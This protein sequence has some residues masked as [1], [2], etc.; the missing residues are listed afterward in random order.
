[1]TI[2]MESLNCNLKL[3]LAVVL[4]GRR[5]PGGITRQDHIKSFNVFYV[6]DSFRA[7]LRSR[8]V[9]TYCSVTLTYHFGFEF[10]FYWS[11]TKTCILCIL[12]LPKYYSTDTYYLFNQYDD[13]CTK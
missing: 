6:K 7:Q 12:Y 9:L 8:G 11:T 4:R 3:V 1:M 10:V 5:M 13:N 2:I